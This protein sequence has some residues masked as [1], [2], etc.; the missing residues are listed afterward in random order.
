MHELSL[1]QNML[2][3][4]AWVKKDHGEKEVSGVTVELPEFG[5]LDEDHFRFHFKEATKGTCW[6]GLSLEI[7]RVPLGVDAKLTHVTFK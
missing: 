6:E 3:V 7:V 1:I 5:S 2:D 4:V